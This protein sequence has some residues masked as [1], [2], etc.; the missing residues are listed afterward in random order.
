MYLAGAYVPCEKDFQ[1]LRGE[2]SK[3][4][5][6]YEQIY[7]PIRNKVIAHK[8]QQTIENVDKLFGKTNIGQIQEFLNFLYQIEH[9]VFDLLYNGRLSEI[10][11]YKFSEDN[12]VQKDVE[13]LLGRVKAP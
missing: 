6:K 11:S 3:H 2:T 10:G 12:F 9:I 4:Q 8:E 5:R 7:R 1:I 13:G